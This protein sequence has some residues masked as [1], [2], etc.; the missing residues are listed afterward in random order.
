MFIR[1]IGRQF[2]R[3]PEL[4]FQIRSHGIDFQ[5]GLLLDVHVT[6]HGAEIGFCVEHREELHTS[7]TLHKDASRA[8][9]KGEHL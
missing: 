4:V 6:D 5:A 9:G 7:Q 8:V 2:D 1:K 3:F